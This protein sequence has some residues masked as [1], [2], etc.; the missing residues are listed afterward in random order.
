MPHETTTASNPVDSGGPEPGARPLRFRAKPGTEPTMA[1]HDRF[2]GPQMILTSVG[3]VMPANRLRS[4]P[5]SPVRA[6][7]EIAEVVG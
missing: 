5:M 3:F 2:P 6:L 1:Q 7:H 4:W